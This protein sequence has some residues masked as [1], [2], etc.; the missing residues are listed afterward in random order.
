MAS[1]NDIPLP[2]PT[3]SV[4]WHNLPDVVVV[5]I[6]GEVDS[7]TAPAMGEVIIAALDRAAAGPCIVDLTE[8]QFLGPRGLATL[9][10]VTQQAEL[11]REPLK[12]VVDANRPVIR[13]IELTGLDEVL[14]LYH[15]VEEALAAE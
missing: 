2:A 12:I 10:D 8:V 1:P 7:D 5:A 14:A 11:R 15:T 9:V 4:H 6:A 13:P 3:L